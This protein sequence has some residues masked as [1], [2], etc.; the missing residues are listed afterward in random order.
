MEEQHELES[1]QGKMWVKFFS[2]GT[3]K[4]MDENLAEAA[5]D[6]YHLRER[7]LWP[8]TGEVYWQGIAVRERRQRM[9]LKHEKKHKQ[10]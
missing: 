4:A 8:R 3:L 2:L 5:G 7:W 9:R 1:R 10:A 6:G